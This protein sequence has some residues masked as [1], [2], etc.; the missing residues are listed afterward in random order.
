MHKQQSQRAAIF[1]AS[2]TAGLDEDFATS[3][4]NMNDTIEDAEELVHNQEKIFS[5]MDSLLMMQKVSRTNST[6]IL[7][8]S[9]LVSNARKNNVLLH[10]LVSFSF[11]CVCTSIFVNNLHGIIRIN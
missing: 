10:D 5:D 4:G 9:A 7:R 6:S 8:E 2:G 1:G 3:I 11:L